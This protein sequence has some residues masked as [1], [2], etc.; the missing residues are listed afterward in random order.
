MKKI[1]SLFVLV[2]ILGLSAS[3]GFAMTKSE[4][5]SAWSKMTAQLAAR[6]AGEEKALAIRSELDAAAVTGKLRDL[7]KTATSKKGSER[8]TAAW[9]ILRKCIPDGDLSRWAEVNYFDIPSITPNMFMVVDALYAAVIEL[10]GI[11]GGEWVAAE[12]LREFSAR[13]HSRYD[14]ISVCPAPVADAIRVVVEKTGLSRNWLPRTV[15]GSLPLARPV[16][17]SVTHSTALMKDMVLLDGA[18]APSSNG[19]YAWDRKTGRI[20]NLVDDNSYERRS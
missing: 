2:V 5:D 19:F 14:F 6:Q 10:S 4:T 17:G 3:C 13:P 11:D 12:L 16:S 20:Y 8:L 15:I 9:S 18:G 7:W 1:V